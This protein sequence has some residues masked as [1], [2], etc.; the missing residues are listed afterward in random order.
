MM[1][2]KV[3]LMYAQLPVFKYQTFDL[4]SLKFSEHPIIPLPPRKIR[5]ADE[6]DD[7][8]E[9]PKNDDAPNE[10]SAD[11]EAANPDNET[12]DTLG[13]AP[14]DGACTSRVYEHH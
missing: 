3:P 9:P 5:Y 13:D 1:A 6:D 11:T 8:N 10:P 12:V 4:E 7:T 14:A 2:S